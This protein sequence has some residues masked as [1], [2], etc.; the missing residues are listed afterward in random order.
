MKH[1]ITEI[2]EEREQTLAPHNHAVQAAVFG[3]N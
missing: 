3:W 1:M 2:K